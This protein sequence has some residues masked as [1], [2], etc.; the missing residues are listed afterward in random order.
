MKAGCVFC[1]IVA[2]DE[3]AHVIG[4]SDRA[5][6]FL[7]V[8]PATDGHT[9]VIPKGHAADIWE[10]TPEDGAA[11]WA[12]VRRMA[13]L[14]R[15]RLTP[16]GLTLFQANGK[17]GWQHVFHFHMHVLPRWIG[18]GLQRPWDMRSGDPQA[19]EAMADRLRVP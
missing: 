19:L 14:L 1:S 17:A 6:A 7:D 8:N 13:S 12:L 2:G 10:L 16:D 3:P 5:L 15:G 18:D 9:L 11:V 4:R